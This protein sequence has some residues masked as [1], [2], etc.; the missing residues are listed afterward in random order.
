MHCSPRSEREK[1]V[2]YPQRKFPLQL[3]CS[4]LGCLTLRSQSLGPV[5]PLRC[6]GTV[7]LWLRWVQMDWPRENSRS[8]WH[9]TLTLRSHTSSLEPST[10]SSSLLSNQGMRASHWLESKLQVRK[11]HFY[12][13]KTKQKTCSKSI[14]LCC[15]VKISVHLQKYK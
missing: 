5:H 14:F 6:L 10:G 7:C 11:D 4:S 1:N 2:F 8:R 13:N 9:R 15:P 12:K 3:I